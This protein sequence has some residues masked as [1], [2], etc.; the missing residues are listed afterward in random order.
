M[1]EITFDDGSLE[2]VAAEY[3]VAIGTVRFE[4]NGAVHTSRAAW[5]W[6]VED[7]QIRWASRFRDRD[8]AIAAI[9]QRMA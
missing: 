8:E 6:L 4:R 7:G 9:E 3:I 5:A 2:E 1:F